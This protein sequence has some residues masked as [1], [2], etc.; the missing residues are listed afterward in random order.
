M[1]NRRI[2][3][4]YPPRTFRIGNSPKK[5]TPALLITVARKPGKR[6]KLVSGSRKVALKHESR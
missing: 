4:E 3:T 1:K 6:K 2:K 5:E